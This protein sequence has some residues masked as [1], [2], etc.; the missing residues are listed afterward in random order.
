MTRQLLPSGSMIAPTTSAG[1]SAS[2][3]NV[4]ECKELGI[5]LLPPDVNESDDQ[6][7]VTDQGIRFGLG[8][9]KSIGMGFVRQLMEERERGGPF[10]S[11]EDFC[12]RLYDTDLNKRTVE[13]L[14]KCGAMDC[15]GAYRSQ[16]LRIYEVVMGAVADSRKRN[17]EGQI[18]LFDL[19]D[20][21]EEKPQQVSRPNI[22][23]LSA[24]EKMDME[25]ETTGLYLSGHPMDDY[26]DK[27]KLAGAVPIGQILEAFG[28]T[29]TGGVP[30]GAHGL[31][32][33]GKIPHAVHQIIP[34]QN[35]VAPGSPH[36]RMI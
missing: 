27:V 7:T 16:L 28:E 35:D 11:L 24:R 12:Q 15:F 30:L 29:E 22:P 26:R 8:A 21:V 9:V 2:E 23:E 5:A 36:R 18:G 20:A 3:T 14:I 6:F 25:K 33:S 34:L 32:V 10:T 17:L 4:A 1:D 13:N 31:T 19:L